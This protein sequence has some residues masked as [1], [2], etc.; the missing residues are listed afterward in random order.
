VFAEQDYEEDQEATG[1]PQ[2]EGEP[3]SLADLR[4]VLGVRVM[5]PYG[6]IG[7]ALVLVSMWSI[8]NGCRYGFLIGMV[9]E[10]FWLWYAICIGSI[11]LAMMSFIF[12]G[13]YLRN[14]ALWKK[15][16]G[17]EKASRPTTPT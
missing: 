11:E 10:L 5:N 8:G 14:W 3:G 2:G 16:N 6:W 7:A 9:A 15:R 4:P 13:V 1:T 17:L 12:A